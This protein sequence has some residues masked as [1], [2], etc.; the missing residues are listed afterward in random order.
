MSPLVICNHGPTHRRTALYTQ[1]TCA[2]C[3][4][5]KVAKIMAFM[6]F[7]DTNLAFF[8]LGVYNLEFSGYALATPLGEDRG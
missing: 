6:S 4:K 5:L 1:Y 3:K 2:K 8:A 7:L